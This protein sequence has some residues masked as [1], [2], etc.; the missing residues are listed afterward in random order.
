MGL[1]SHLAGGRFEPLTH[2]LRRVYKIDHS[3]IRAGIWVPRMCFILLFFW[4]RKEDYS[5]LRPALSGR[6]A[7][8]QIGCA[9]LSN[10]FFLSVRGSNRSVEPSAPRDLATIFI[11][12]CR[13]EDHRRCAPRPFGS[14]SADQI[15]CA[16]LSNRFFLSVRGSN[17]SVEPSAPRTFSTI[18]KNWCRKEDYSALRASPFGVGLRPIKLAAPICRTGFLSV[19][20]S[21]GSV[22]PSAPRT[23]RHFYKLV[24]Q[25]GFEPLTHALRMRC[26]TN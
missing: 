16:N 15:G 7:A 11:N 2:A 4:C 17:R 10:R 13:K 12:W 8:D 26:S 14:A 25:R 19:R 18:F 3:E 5:A 22:E 1:H 20:G 24:P 9:N 6:P 23:S 21:N